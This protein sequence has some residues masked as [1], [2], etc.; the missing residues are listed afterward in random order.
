MH[1]RNGRRVVNESDLIHVVPAGEFAPSSI[2]LE[3]RTTDFDIFRNIVREYAEEF[4]NVPEADGRGGRDL[5]FEKATSFSQLTKAKR[6]GSLTISV[7]GIGLDSVCLKPELLTVAV[8]EADVFDAIFASLAPENDEG[9]LLVGQEGRGLL[10]VEEN[11]SN[12]ATD[13]ATS[14]T[15]AAC[16]MLAWRHRASLGLS[17]G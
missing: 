7:L 17:N 16:L 14:A 8:F 12:Y 5:N 3:A 1:R 6:T 2:T 13:P 15:G 4:L 10:F 11:V 9:V